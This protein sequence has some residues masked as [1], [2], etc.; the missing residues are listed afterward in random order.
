MGLS[1]RDYMHERRDG[2]NKVLHFRPVPKKISVVTIVFYLVATLYLLYRAAF[3]WQDSQ[4][5][6]RMPAP[7]IAV[8]PAEV[9][10]KVEPPRTFAP[11]IPQAAQAEPNQL[12]AP[13]TVSKCVVNGKVT[14]SDAACP[15]EAIVGRVKL[16][17]T[18]PGTVSQKPMA[19]SSP[20]V[21]SQQSD[22]ASEPQ[23][24]IHAPTQ[25]APAKTAECR[26]LDEV[27]KEVDKQALQ[28]LTLQQQDLLRVDRKK[29]RDR[30]FFLG[31]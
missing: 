13:G 4:L 1:D 22:T 5:Q 3:W 25:A 2:D 9:P 11:R 30:Q 6:K 12:P 28:P 7:S 29:A 10:P 16:I 26:H 8:I 21:V 19:V 18:D 27:V 24:T 14:Y 20:S 23:P 31:C 17:P 15:K